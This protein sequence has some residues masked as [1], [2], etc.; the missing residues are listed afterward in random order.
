M[1]SFAFPLSTFFTTTV[2]YN[3]RTTADAEPNYLFISHSNFFVTHEH[4][5]E[6]LK[7]A[8]VRQEIISQ[9]EGQTENHG[10]GLGGT[11][12][13]PDCFTLSCKQPQFLL[14]VTG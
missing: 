10:P 9:L 14:E 4:E 3:A 5:L 7:L 11:D 1:Q 13:H 2:R 6:I 8:H 12:P